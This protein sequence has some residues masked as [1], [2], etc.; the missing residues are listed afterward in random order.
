MC[1][2]LCIISV[3]VWIHIEFGM[4]LHPRFW[5]LS[6][7]VWHPCSKMLMLEKA[8]QIHQGICWFCWYFIVIIIFLLQ[9][10][11]KSHVW[12]CGS[13]FWFTGEQSKITTIPSV[14]VFKF[15]ILTYPNNNFEP[16]YLSLSIFELWNVCKFPHICH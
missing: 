8:I 9:S 16:G 11:W 3:N 5:F 12:N 2:G 15:T 4:Q 10:W 7:W 13:I 1:V 14:Y 6:I